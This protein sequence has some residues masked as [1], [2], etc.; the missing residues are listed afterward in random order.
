[1]LAG[2]KPELERE[3]FL[4]FD[5]NNLQCARWKQWKLHVARHNTAA[6]SPAPAGGRINLPLSAPELYDV[7]GDVDESYD[8]APEHPEIVAEIRSRMERLMQG[9]P[10]VVRKAWEQTKARKVSPRAAG[11]YPAL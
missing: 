4:Y 10:D 9:F 6:Y 8:V 11:N 1:L 7:V 2:Q 3:A 5:G